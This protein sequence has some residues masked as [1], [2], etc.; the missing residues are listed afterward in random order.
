MPLIGAVKAAGQTAAQM[1]S[2]KRVHLIRIVSGK[3]PELK[4]SVGDLLQPG[5]RR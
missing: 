5:D 2:G 1:G 3:R 4:A